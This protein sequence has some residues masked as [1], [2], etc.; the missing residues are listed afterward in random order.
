[1]LPK[2]EN[3]VQL[4]FIEQKNHLYRGYGSLVNMKLG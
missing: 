1:M 3:L 4:A 2:H